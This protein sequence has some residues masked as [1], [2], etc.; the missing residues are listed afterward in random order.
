MLWFYRYQMSMF[1]LA[2]EQHK[3]A[4]QAASVIAARCAE[5]GA[6]AMKPSEALTM[7][8]EKPLAAAE[9]SLLALKAINRRANSIQ[10]AR[11]ALKPYAKRTGSNARRLG[12]KK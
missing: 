1:Q 9:A 3:V 6:G 8:W 10:V 12:R 4:V 5:M 7:V 11:S 2:A